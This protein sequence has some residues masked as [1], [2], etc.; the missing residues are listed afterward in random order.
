PEAAVVLP[1]DALNDFR[2]EASV[3]GRRTHAHLRRARGVR[4]AEST[5]ARA[6]ALASSRAGAVTDRANRTEADA[7]AAT[8]AAFADA[9]Q[10]EP[11]CTERVADRIAPHVA[12]G[13]H[14]VV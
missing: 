12:A 11:A 10:A 1:N 3:D 6:E 2:R 5:V 8:A 14:R 13:A 9:R 4:T 7:F